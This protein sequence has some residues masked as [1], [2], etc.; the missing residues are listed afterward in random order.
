MTLIDTNLAA[1][2][3]GVTPRTIRRWV[4]AGRLTNHGTPKHIRINPHQLPEPTP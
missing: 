3:A 1:I 4:H 2:L